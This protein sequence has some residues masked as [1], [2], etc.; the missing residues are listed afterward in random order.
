[1][2][3]DAV[4]LDTNTLPAVLA[5]P[6][7]RRVTRSQMSVWVGLSLGSE[8]TVHVRVAG[9]PATEVTGTPATPTQVGLH[10]WLAVVQAGSPGGPTFAPG[11]LYEYRLTSPGWPAEPNWADLA[12]GTTQPAFPGPPAAVDDLVVLHA[13]CRK[14][15]GGGR[16]ALATATAQVAERVIA[17]IANPRPH[18]MVL[19]GDQIYADEVPS[20]MVPRVRRIAD[21][22]VGIDETGVFGPMPPINGRQQPS[23]SFGLTSEAAANHLWTLGEYLAAYLLYWS[24]ALWPAD[25][26]VWAD[27]DPTSD[28]PAGL[29]PEELAAAEVTWNDQHAAVER[30]RVGLP[31]VRR[32]LATVPTLMVPDDHEV[33]DDWNLDHAWATAVYANPAGSRI[34]FNGMLAYAL[35]QHWGNV[36]SRFATP[37]TPEAA[38]LATAI[39]TGASA[40]SAAAR[41]LLGVPAGPPAAPPTELRDPLAPDA[42]RYDIQLGPADGWPVR[43]IGLDERTV[44]E[45]VRIDRPAARISLTALAQ[46]LPGPP[47]GE[48]PAA[49]TLVAAPSPV[50]GTHVVEHLLQPAAGLLP[51][52]T[53]YA[54]FESWPAATAQHQELLRRL[55]AYA[56]VVL[57]GGDVH[58]AATAALAYT[59]AGATTRAAGVTSS[60]TKNADAK[61]MI[62]H[63]LG[64]FAMRVGLERPRRF[65]GFSSLDAVQRAALASPPAAG[66]VLP[67]DDL[68]DVLLGRVFRAGQVSPAILSQEVAAA[69]GFGA[70]EWSYDVE[71]VDDERMPGPGELLTHMAGA[72]APWVG[73]D[74]PKSIAMVLALRASDL[75]RIGRVWDGL[76]QTSMLTFAGSLVLTHT[77]TSPVGEDPT[78]P[79]THTTLTTAAL[80]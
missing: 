43:V 5:G 63:L 67:W 12:I 27:V 66:T 23:E 14:P 51:G 53:T 72:P 77:L 47:S 34:V 28:L 59:R 78:N 21:D 19:S 32:L 69:Y 73:W 7:L 39:H 56:P 54:D 6:V 10:L 65:V 11:S 18:L 16:D 58:Y 13:S 41:D 62:L 75:H 42:L 17:G 2:A 64:D 3:L 74:P 33:T 79:V 52:G 26:P 36:P 1:M 46:A 20:P 4:P 40:D 60:A 35:C 25:V 70:G 9:Q 57:L 31:E 22:L 38:C 24:D 50:L 68:V 61:T 55:A 48:P 29:T 80:V 45:F 71:P 44:R 49:V 30:F 37:G 76:P 8:V 15:H